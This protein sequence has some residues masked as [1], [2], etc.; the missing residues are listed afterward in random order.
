MPRERG[1]CVGPTEFQ[2]LD[3]YLKA[4]FTLWLEQLMYRTRINFL[5]KYYS[6]PESIGLAQIPEELLAKEDEYEL[7]TE[8]EDGFIFEEERLAEA[9]SR[10][11]LM[12]KRILSMSFVD[13]LSPAEIAE[14][15]HCSVR[16][17]YN[18][19]H[20]AIKALRDWLS[21]D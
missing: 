2:D 15:L 19:K 17:V 6:A 14:R 21:E 7:S 20:R 4:R 18:Q 13:Q 12:K 16:T 5:Q 10:L 3:G 11:P 9:Y 8:T 1:I